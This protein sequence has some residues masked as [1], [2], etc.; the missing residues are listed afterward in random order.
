MS[1][2]ASKRPKAYSYVRFSTPEQEQGDSLRRQLEKAQQ[3]AEK[4][5]LE[6]DTSLRDTGISAYRGAN[7]TKGKLRRFL[8][9]VETGAVPEGSYLLIE[10][11]DRISRQGA[12]ETW[13]T[14]QEIINAGVTIVTLANGEKEY[15]RERLN[16]DPFAIFE[17]VM[18]LI[19]AKEES[20]TKAGRLKAAW[21][22][23]RTRAADG[24]PLTRM[25]PGWLRLNEKTGKIELIPERAKVVR[26]IFRMALKGTGKLTIAETLN[27]EGVPTFDLASSKTDKRRRSGFWQPSYV[28]KILAN[29]AVTGTLIPYTSEEDGERKKRRVPL[30]PIP[31]YY[32]KVIDAET[33]D[34]VRT[35]LKESAA[36]LRGRH[37]CKEIKNV[38]GG[39]LRCPLCGTGM[40]RIQKGPKNGPVRLVCSNAKVGGGC[41]Y[42]TVKFDD[43][44]H[45]FFQNASYI[46]GTAPSGED[47]TAEEERLAEVEA[48]LEGT[49]TAIQ[50]I[51]EMV[52][53]GG[54]SP[55]LTRR[56]KELEAGQSE[57][58]KEAERLHRIIGQKSDRVVAK[59]L[60]DLREALESEPLNLG[61]INAL[62]RMLFSQVVVDYQRGTL[63]FQWRHGGETSVVFAWVQKG[64]QKPAPPA[65][66]PRRKGSTAA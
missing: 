1:D 64:K 49:D 11:F 57:T 62:L 65:A 40:A 27:R 5:N 12:W 33:F 3:Y 51:L 54:K 34:R 45:A 17:M 41:K 7:A 14:L 60:G 19:R 13:P 63:D 25:L 37:S 52:Q 35:L 42:H 43:V 50:N 4:H 26:R 56:L 31:N 9:L 66:Q 24:K 2:S 59:R 55:T 47:A 36:P 23:K 46:I 16:A 21:S 30:D 28:L 61:R 20:D 38:L 8:D 22:N 44:E 18:V 10:S 29:P 53:R 39:L 48:A 32:P 15:S 58:R 6:L